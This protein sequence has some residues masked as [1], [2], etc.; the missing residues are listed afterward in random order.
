MTKLL[1]V[2]WA[3]REQ[4]LGKKLMRCMT[5]YQEKI[6]HLWGFHQK[7]PTQMIPQWEESEKYQQ[8]VKSLFHGAH[9]CESC[10]SVDVRNLEGWGDIDLTALVTDHGD[11]VHLKWSESLSRPLH[12]KTLRERNRCINWIIILLTSHIRRSSVNIQGP[13]LV[14]LPFK[15]VPV[16]RIIK[17]SQGLMFA[18]TERLLLWVRNEYRIDAIVDRSILVT[19]WKGFLIPQARSPNNLLYDWFGQNR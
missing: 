19:S 14:I 2:D 17:T 11:I 7:W 1:L 15:P 6:T 18:R 9:F 13:A 5:D 4:K 16:A 8:A 12:C 3:Y 10:E